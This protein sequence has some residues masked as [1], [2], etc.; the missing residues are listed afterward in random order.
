MNSCSS[1]FGRILLFIFIGISGFI[2]IAS[3]LEVEPEVRVGE[4][5]FKITSLVISEERR[6]GFESWATIFMKV[7]NNGKTSIELNYAAETASLVNER[8]YE[9]KEHRSREFIGLP[10][11]ASDTTLK[12]GTI[13]EPGGE[14]G[15][16]Y[17]LYYSNNNEGQTVGNT[18]N[19][20]AFFVAVH[21][22]GEGRKEIKTGYPVVFTGLHKSTAQAVNTSAVSVPEVKV[23]ELSF[24]V[25]SLQISAD[26]GYTNLNLSSDATIILKITNHGM[27]P[28]ALNYVNK[29][30]I[31]INE[32]GYLWELDSPLSGRDFIGTYLVNNNTGSTKYVVDP[33][34]DMMVTIPLNYE[35]KPG[36]TVGN[37]FN[38]AA[39][40]ISYQDLGEGNIKRLRAYPLSFVGLHKTVV[41]PEVKPD[42]GNIPEST[43]ELRVGELG[44]SVKSVQ[45]K[46]VKINK[47]S[48]LKISTDRFDSNGKV[49]L[50]ITNHGDTPIALNLVE[51]K[52]ILVDENGHYCLDITRGNV[53]GI[54]KATRSEASVDRP[55]AAGG[56]ANV[57]IYVTC[58]GL[59]GIFNGSVFD[60]AAE[61]AA[62]ADQ[63]EGRVTKLRIYPVA[64]TGLHKAL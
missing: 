60:F 36:Q 59:T 3:A 32:R 11:A 53:E 48:F 51:R 35:G 9:W 62:Y 56:Q 30:T 10:I 42:A 2:K 46:S 54:P 34:G 52:L 1:F 50:V 20:E 8:G 63:G 16:T 27:S 45:I 14:I 40:F 7:K 49:S 15:V 61:F 13:L 26:T 55:I 22:I 33:K 6:N 41:S 38:F 31:F 4:L 25:V 64:F 21:D 5:S 37:S 39:E 24:Q 57:S 47:D 18:F 17:P 43:P 58:G 28:I 23:G 12:T 44:F 19:L 29:K